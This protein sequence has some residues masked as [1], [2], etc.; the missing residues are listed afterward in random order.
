MPQH[1][2]VEG[3][4][5]AEKVHNEEFAHQWMKIP[6]VSSHAEG[7]IMAIKE[8]KI[9]TRDLKKKR[10]EKENPSFYF[11]R[12]YCND[13]KEDIFHLLASCGHL[14]AGLYLPVRHDDV[15]RSLYNAIIQKEQPSH[16]YVLR[17]TE[18]WQSEKIE[19]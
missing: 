5:L 12:R 18:I 19:L 10:E 6:N 9:N 3:K 11:L 16:E 4:Q 8:Q 1:G 13:S 17:N 15:G 14:S 7:Y 2:F